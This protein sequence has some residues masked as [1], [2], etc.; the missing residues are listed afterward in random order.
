MEAERCGWLALG[1]NIDLFFF[2]SR[3]RHTSSPRDWSSD[4]CSSDLIAN[5]LGVPPGDALRKIL[6]RAVEHGK[7]RR[8]DTGLYADVSSFIEPPLPDPRV[9]FHGLGAY[10][11]SQTGEVGTFRRVRQT[12]TANTDPLGIFRNK[13]SKCL[14]FRG[15][16]AGRGW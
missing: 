12:V 5:G 1:L 2:S 4:V 13:Q 16:W 11:M 9:R 7:L 14:T 3:R 6:S 15:D 8:L 10:W